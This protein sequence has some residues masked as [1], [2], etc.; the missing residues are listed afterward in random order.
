M[1]MHWVPDNQV[2][3]FSPARCSHGRR[4]SVLWPPRGVKGFAGEV[5]LLARM[6][7]RKSQ[8]PRVA[9]SCPLAPW[10]C[11]KANTRHILPWPQ[12]DGSKL[13]WV[14]SAAHASLYLSPITKRAEVNCLLYTKMHF[15]AVT[16]SRASR[17]TRKLWASRLWPSVQSRISVDW[18]LISKT[19]FSFKEAQSSGESS[20]GHTACC[21]HFSAE[22][23][24]HRDKSNSI[25]LRGNSTWAKPSQVG[26]C[27]YLLKKEATPPQTS[28][29]YEKFL[30]ILFSSNVLN[31]FSF[32]GW[33]SNLST[34]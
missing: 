13:S 28:Q 29:W 31:S 26:I 15:M 4:H 14:F 8:S 23:P 7:Q 32:S 17:C 24:K 21:N 19:V 18:R 9:P 22:F 34:Q 6:A 20:N 33:I 3:S 16:A 10:K 5:R 1:R 11:L 30:P 25:S 12:M 2:F 27:D